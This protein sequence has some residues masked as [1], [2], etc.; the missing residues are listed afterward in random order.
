MGDRH[1]GHRDRHQDEGQ[2][3]GGIGVSFAL[4]VDFKRQCTGDPLQAARKG[5]GGTELPEAPGKGQHGS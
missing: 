2:G 3:D 1:D 5:E 4:E